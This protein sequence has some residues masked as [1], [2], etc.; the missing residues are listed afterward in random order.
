MFRDQAGN[1]LHLHIS[2]R[3][4]KLNESNNM[5]TSENVFVDR[6]RRYGISQ[7]GESFMVNI[8]LLAREFL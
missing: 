4:D 6:A 3:R 7:L 1:G 2:I 5:M 8:P